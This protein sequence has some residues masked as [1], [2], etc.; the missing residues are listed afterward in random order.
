MPVVPLRRDKRSTRRGSGR[1]TS[2][3]ERRFTRPRCQRSRGPALRASQ[4]SGLPYSGSVDWDQLEC[5]VG[6]RRCDSCR[7]RQFNLFGQR[8]RQRQTVR[9]GRR[10][11]ANPD[12]LGAGDRDPLVDDVSR[13]TFSFGTSAAW[14]DS[15]RARSHSAPR[16]PGRPVAVRSTIASRCS[17]ATFRR[18]R[19]V[20]SPRPPPAC[21]SAK[22]TASHR[23][24]AAR[25]RRRGAASLPLG[26]RRV[27]GRRTTDRRSRS[28]VDHA[29]GYRSRNQSCGA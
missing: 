10:R 23:T 11:E 3:I 5:R 1:P 13:S 19:Q 7:A 2:M 16:L 22:S 21:S 26:L 8:Q 9:V 17:R 15:P 25:A 18:V 14:M 27:I 4:S 29:T 24:C 6:T 20:S 28:S 12:D